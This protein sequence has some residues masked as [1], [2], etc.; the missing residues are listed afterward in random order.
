M[1]SGGDSFK[2]V[3]DLI[4]RTL[5]SLTLSYSAAVPLTLLL[6]PLFNILATQ[7]FSKKV[8]T[9]SQIKVLTEV[10]L[11]MRP[12]YFF[13]SWTYV[14]L[15]L[16]LERYVP[17]ISSLVNNP[18]YAWMFTLSLYISLY[19]VLQ[20]LIPLGVQCLIVLVGS[21]LGQKQL[22]KLTTF[23]FVFI[24]VSAQILSGP[25]Y[26]MIFDAGFLPFYEVFWM[27]SYLTF[28]DKYLTLFFKYAPVVVS[29]VQWGYIT[30]GM[31]AEAFKSQHH[32]YEVPMAI[33][34]GALTFLLSL[35]PSL[36]V[37]QVL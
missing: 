31:L 32:T 37:L 7:Y 1:P 20:M 15:Y 10:L 6:I 35:D 25:W 2:Y 27:N 14:I 36:M 17:W 22:D 9:R 30:V 19:P 23:D 8:L 26:T 13:G 34:T 24:L 11:G 3:S 5:V 16:L 12:V 33:F 18:Q 4:S 21:G 28:K 29:M